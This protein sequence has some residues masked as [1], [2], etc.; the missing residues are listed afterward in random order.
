MRKSI[1]IPVLSLV[2]ISG[3][4][5]TDEKTNSLSTQITEERGEGV[6]Y[7][8]QPEW[9]SKAGSAFPGDEGKYIYGV[10]LGESQKK[11]MRWE[12]AESRARAAIA[13]AMKTYVAGM[14]KDYMS[15]AVDTSQTSA[16][17]YTTMVSKQV[18]EETL[19]G[20]EIVDTWVDADGTMYKLARMPKDTIDE[21]AKAAA[22]AQK[23]FLLESRRENALQELDA[24]LKKVDIREKANLEKYGLVAPVKVETSKQSDS[25][26]EK[27]E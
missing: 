15:D 23:R 27:K 25:T 17:E 10:G 4:K 26:R 19:R 3:C 22:N 5:T 12:K 2:I 6:N 20:C 9:V 7:G 21:L 1:L 16:E 24:E 11:A 14:V 18:Y 13:R 8:K